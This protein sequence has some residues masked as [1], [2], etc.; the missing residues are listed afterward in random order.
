MV[1]FGFTVAEDPGKNGE[2][3]SRVRYEEPRRHISGVVRFLTSGGGILRLER[4]AI[5]K[6]STD[7]LSMS[8]TCSRD[9]QKGSPQPSWCHP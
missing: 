7:Q 6:G 9:L 3:M 4:W 2:K 8:M 5:P 1:D